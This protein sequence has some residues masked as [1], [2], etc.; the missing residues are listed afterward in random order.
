MKSIPVLYEDKNLIFIN[1]PSGMLV[2]DMGEQSRDKSSLLTYLEARFKR[3]FYPVHWLDRGCSGIVVFA[4]NSSFARE[5]TRIWQSDAI[6]Q[7]TL[8]LVKGSFLSAG[9]FS[10]PLRNWNGIKQPAVT[11]YSPVWTRGSL[12][13]ME[14]TTMTECPHQIRRHFS[15]RCAN[16]IGDRRF[17]Q[18]KWNWLFKSCY[19]LRRIFMHSSHIK[20]EMNNYRHAIEIECPLAEDLKSVLRQIELFPSFYQSETMP[21][22]HL[23]SKGMRMDLD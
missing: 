2:Y 21:G 10:F 19:N 13:L 9:T 3:P 12:S 15:R 16:V 8:V 7:K 22:G 20:L 11:Q 4:K 1:K 14:V 5:L 18:G 17:G 6:S 23:F